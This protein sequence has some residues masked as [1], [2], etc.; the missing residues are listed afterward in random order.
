MKEA[1]YKFE[2]QKEL[3]KNINLFKKYNGANSTRYN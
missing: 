3:F 1:N 2:V